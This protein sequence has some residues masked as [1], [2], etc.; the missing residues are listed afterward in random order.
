V[1]IGILL[2][3]LDLQYHLSTCLSYYQEPDIPAM[4]VLAELAMTPHWC[5]AGYTEMLEVV[6]DT[7]EQEPVEDTAEL[8][9]D[10]AGA[11]VPSPL[12]RG[13]VD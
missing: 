13:I 9:G 4:V 5:L 2:D 12:D 10:I 11:I 6:E 8:I 3:R 7:A 1:Q